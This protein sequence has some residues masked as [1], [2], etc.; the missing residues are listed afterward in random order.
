VTLLPLQGQYFHSYDLL[1]RASHL[2]RDVLNEGEVDI[3]GR[4]ALR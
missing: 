4:E 2:K 1:A 3:K